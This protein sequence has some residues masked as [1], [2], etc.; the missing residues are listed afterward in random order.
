MNIENVEG[1]ELQL[2]TLKNK[3]DELFFIESIQAEKAFKKKLSTTKVNELYKNGKISTELLAH[4]QGLIEGKKINN[5]KKA[6]KESLQ[7]FVKSFNSYA[8]LAREQDIE[9]GYIVLTEKKGTA[10]QFFESL[11]T[12]KGPAAV[13]GGGNALTKLKSIFVENKK[14]AGEIKEQEFEVGE[15]EKKPAF[16]SESITKAL[17]SLNKN[18]DSI[19]KV[20]SHGAGQTVKIQEVFKVP[21]FAT[22][23]GLAE[24]ATV[25]DFKKVEPGEKRHV[26]TIVA[27]KNALF[28]EGK[29]A[30]LSVGK[31]DLMSLIPGYAYGKIIPQKASG[32]KIYYVI[33]PDLSEEE[34][35]KIEKIKNELIEV[36]TI[37]ELSREKMFEK[38]ENII[39]RRGYTFS[40]QG[41]HKLMYYLS[42]DLLGIGRIEPLMHDP[43]I[44]DIECDGVDVPVYVVHQKEGHLA[45]NI[46]FKDMELLEDFIIKLAQLSKTYV[47]YAS[48]L[49]D[50]VLPDG[51]RVNAVLTKSVSTKGPSF[52]IRLFPEKPLS[53]THLIENGTVSPEMMAYLWTV[54]EFKKSMLITGPT[55]SGKTTLLN[56]ISMFIPYGNRV[57]SIED[58]RELNLKH[59]NWLPQVARQGFGPPDASG[60]RFGEVDL[61]TLIRESFRQRPDYL[62]VGEVRGKETFV[63]F[64]GMASGHCS[65]A[66]L[67]ARSVNDVV[68]R[69]TTPPINLYPSLLESADIIL[70][71]GFA[72]EKE[73]RRKIRAVAEVKKYNAA[74]MKL[75][76]NDLMENSGIQEIKSVQG[77]TE[78]IA[79]FFPITGK[80][81]L[82]KEISQ[83]YNIP[84]QALQKKIEKRSAFL[85]KLAKEHV[86]E[87]EEFNKRI[88]EFKHAERQAG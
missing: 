55:A 23:S 75:E 8:K 78:S 85:A 86:L 29:K 70:N 15:K 14:S 10:E 74:E 66:T 45:S 68:S 49:V 21:V 64:Q 54:L 62:I 2:A 80:S 12:P 67:H 30:A 42:R 60:K 16:K 47:S 72:G 73:I 17:G 81:N 40:K 39:A 27:L 76:Y 5:G 1:M 6:R 50:S 19:K 88:G 51:S 83:E 53:P 63:L 87:F 24:K 36:I 44:E 28:E 13:T 37:E 58:T 26:E 38:V 84:I 43:L 65:L 11:T 22:G 7:E 56:A 32:E 18:I 3:L 69:L 25:A 48:P 31:Q 46:I 52:T 59:E 33:E 4:I 61:M 79:E 9:T 77:K 71:L 35:E 34:R 57:V 20:F 82:L 41:R